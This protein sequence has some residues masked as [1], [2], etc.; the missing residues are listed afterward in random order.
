M[1]SDKPSLAILPLRLNAPSGMDYLKGAYRD[2][3]SSRIG[4]YG[5]IL[6]E[7]APKL[8]AAMDKYGAS[9]WS[10]VK[11]KSLAKEIGA[12][13]ILDGSLSIIGDDLSL[14]VRLIKVDGWDIR[15]MTYKGK[16]LGSFTDMLDKSA[17][18]ARGIIVGLGNSTGKTMK[19]NGWKSRKLSLALK[20]IAVA[21]LDNDGTME[22]VAIDDKNLYIY[23]FDK[24]GLRLKKE[25]KGTGPTL[26]Y[27]IAVGDFNGNGLPEIYLS[28]K[29]MEK[30][31][32]RV[33]EFT[34]KDF[35]VIADDLPWFMRAV[36]GADKAFLIGEKFR[37]IDGL[38]GGV[39]FLKWK[40]GVMEEDS[41]LDMPKWMDLYGFTICDV[42]GDGKDDF[43]RLDENDRIRIYEKVE[44]GTWK[45]TWKST[46]YYGGSI[47]NIDFEPAPAEQKSV[48]VKAE[49]IC[50]KLMEGGRREVITSRNEAGTRIFKNISYE[51]GD[52]RGL[53]WND[54]GLEDMWRTKKINGYVADFAV[55]DLNKDGHDEIV[56]VVVVKQPS[57]FSTGESLIV[58][59]SPERLH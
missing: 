12:S 53:L 26:N 9:D 31:A 47:N 50:S 37:Q 18:E 25:F 57:I 13:F 8:Q 16:G 54:F 52:V 35:T 41:L 58:T 38:Y 48:N 17:L 10:E 39:K 2:V 27:N 42:T 22:L 6:I 49:V 1:A 55:A 21:D 3:L 5:D 11:S 51:S 15:P 43:V 24:D 33:I 56:E 59:L 32:S 45:Q 19:D 40:S 34:G 14:D 44:A 28:R 23:T 4:S 36:K 46:D 30:A 7:D 20:G 29:Y